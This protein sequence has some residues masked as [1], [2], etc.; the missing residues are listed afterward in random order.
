MKMPFNAEACKAYMPMTRECIPIG[1]SKFTSLED[2]L[3]D[4]NENIA[5][6]SKSDF[7]TAWFYEAVKEE[8]LHL[9]ELVK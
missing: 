2:V 8:V 6:T 4:A 9:M 7:M 5:S 1:I 3:A